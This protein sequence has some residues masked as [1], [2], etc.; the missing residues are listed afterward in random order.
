MNELKHYG[1]LGMKWGVR[2]TPEE[3][4]HRTKKHTINA[5]KEGIK[6]Y[7]LSDNEKTGKLTK[8]EKKKA[9][10]DKKLRDVADFFEKMYDRSNELVK[11][12][13]ELESELTNDRSVDKD[14]LDYYKSKKETELAIQKLDYKYSMRLIDLK[15]NEPEKAKAFEKSMAK[16]VK[17]EFEMLRNFKY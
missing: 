3:L 9:K 1:I 14:V 13:D 6:D 7:K 12:L 15:I 4:G 5:N 16:I 2:R 11:K 17:K 10:K 8:E